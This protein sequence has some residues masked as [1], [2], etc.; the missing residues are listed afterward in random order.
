MALLVVPFQRS[1]AASAS[2]KPHADD[3]DARRSA[4]SALKYRLKKVTARLAAEEDGLQV[5]DMIAGMALDEVTGG[6][7]GYLE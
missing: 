5:A 6:T 7:P 1:S 4:Q 3:A 2:H